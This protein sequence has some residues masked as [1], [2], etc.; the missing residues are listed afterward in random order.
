MSLSFIESGFVP[1]DG[2]RRGV[3]AAD[4]SAAAE[5]LHLAVPPLMDAGG[6]TRVCVA[7]YEAAQCPF[8]SRCEHAHHF[9]ELNGYTQNKLLETVPV[10][11]IPKHFVAPLNSNSS[12]GNNK[13]DRTFYATDGNAA[14]YTATAAVDGGVAHRSLG[15]GHG[16]K[17][18]TS[19]NRRSKRTARLYDISG[20]NTNLCD[21]SFSS[22][23]SSTDTLLL[24]G[25]VHDSKDVSPQKGTRRDEGME[26]FRI[27][28]PPRCRYPHRNTRGTY[29]D[30]LGIQ[31][32]A[33]QEE[34][35]TSYRR[36]QKEYKSMKQVDPQGADAHDT[37]V[38]EARNVLGHPVLRSEYDRTVSAFWSSNIS[39]SKDLTRGTATLSSANSSRSINM[40]ATTNTMRI[41][42]GPSSADMMSLTQSGL[43][44]DSIW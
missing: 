33:T 38:V 28:L 26:A 11:S 7:F 1:S 20:S 3:E 17:E 34:I 30:V 44:E 37:I 2:M 13:N 12:S 25:S 9:S 8:D 27:R 21:N 4:T 41:A 31:R 19:T 14:N 22:L 36:W 35:I 16:E 18:K 15:G 23:A 32:T 42:N 5:L 29:Y 39:C 43:P 6:K 10:E 24:L 40:E